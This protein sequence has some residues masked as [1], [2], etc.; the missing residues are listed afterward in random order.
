MDQG[1]GSGLDISE[2]FTSKPTL[3][4][5]ARV[6]PFK[7]W[8]KPRKQFIRRFQ[9]KKEAEQLISKLNFNE[10]RPLRYLCLPGEDM[11]D[12]RVLHNVCKSKNIKL[13]Y[14]GFKSGGE[15]K[16]DDSEFQISASEVRNLACIHRDSQGIIDEIQSVGDEKSKAYDYVKRLGSFDIINLDLCNCITS[17]SRL[18]APVEIT[19]FDAL[20]SLLNLQIAQRTE[21]WI[22]FLT[23]L[24]GPN[25]VDRNEMSKIWDC[26]T[27]NCR[28]FA[29]FKTEF[30][31]FLGST[32]PRSYRDIGRGIGITKFAQMFGI[33]L[34]KWLLQLMMSGQ[35]L[36][37]VKML[38][39]YQFRTGTGNRYPTMISMAFLFEPIIEQRIDR[40]GLATHP[41]EGGSTRIDEIRVACDTISSALS[42]KDLDLLMNRDGTLSKEMT[43][44]T[45][46]LLKEARYVISDYDSWLSKNMPVL[47]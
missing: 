21:P 44:E 10:D 37:T 47:H 17:R 19:Y 42:F 24:A 30:E 34:S 13:K 15:Y 8:H 9:W 4:K 6:R 2:A 7:P 36:C 43:E 14:L 18:R 31:K 12:I 27:Y 26:V 16:E 38:Q 46:G 25:E 41:V 39:G 3:K 29:E 23:T 22:L 40:S 33:G 20:E 45:K 32:I 35:P 1:S 5:G 11:L 28:R